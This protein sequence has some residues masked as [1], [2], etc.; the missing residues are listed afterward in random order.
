MVQTREQY[1]FCHVAL[2]H[3]VRQLATEG[4]ELDAA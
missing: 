3:F 4:G 2:L 1:L